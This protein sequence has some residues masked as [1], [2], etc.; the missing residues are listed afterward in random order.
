VH[1]WMFDH[2]DGAEGWTGVHE[3]ENVDDDGFTGGVASYVH[4]LI[5]IAIVDPHSH[6]LHRTYIY[7]S[8]NDN[9]FPSHPSF[10]HLPLRTAM[11]HPFPTHA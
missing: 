1:G 4:T 3:D 5:M 9:I 6:C 8:N 7:A 10:P 11:P 2:D